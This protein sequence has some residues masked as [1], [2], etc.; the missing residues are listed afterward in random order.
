V[1]VICKDDWP[2]FLWKSK[3]WKFLNYCFQDTN[4]E[5]GQYLPIKENAKQ[6]GVGLKA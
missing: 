6:F 4:D 2:L 5:G 1:K 3:I